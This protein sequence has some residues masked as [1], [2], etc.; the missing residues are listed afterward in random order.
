[1]TLSES[2]KHPDSEK[3]EAE[4]GEEAW[5]S[6]PDSRGRVQTLCGPTACA[7]TLTDLRESDSGRYRFWF[8]TNRG[9]YSG[10]P[11]VS[12]TVT[13]DFSL[14]QRRESF[15]RADLQCLSSCRPDHQS[16]IWIRNRRK[17]LKETSP[18]VSVSVHPADTYSCSLKGNQDGFMFP[19][20]DPPLPPSVS[21]SPSAEV[22]EGSSVT[23]TCSSD[24]NPA[25]SYSWYKDSITSSPSKD[26]QLVF[27]SIQSSDS[28]RF[29]CK[30]ENQLGWKWSEFKLIDGSSV[31]LTCSSDANPAASYSWYKE[32]EE[33]PKVSG[34]SFTIAD[35][36]LE[37]SGNYS[38]KAENIRGNQSSTVHLEVK[39]QLFSSSQ[40]QC[41]ET[42]EDRMKMKYLL[43]S[44]LH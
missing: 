10:S 44:V 29:I 20:A 42:Q 3:L 37:H 18:S 22:E 6:D 27:S 13:G 11:G 35:V 30:A 36:R 33:S 31:T 8:R 14:T 41:N 17:I 39:G 5:R 9:S 34:Q 4:T 25:A 40:S 1:L 43:I 38:C 26:S 16:Y 28:G 24:A 32:D 7:L 15:T 21:V 2:I 12:L 19:P 23:L